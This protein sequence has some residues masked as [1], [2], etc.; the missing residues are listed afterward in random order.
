VISAAA[1]RYLVAEQASEIGAEIELALEPEGRDTLA[2]VALAAHLAARRDPL[3]TV[4]VVPSDHLIPDRDAFARSAAEAARVAASG[5]IVVLGIE[6][7]EASA[8]YGYI[9]RGPALPEGG[10]PLR[11]S[12]RSRASR[13]RG[14]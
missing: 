6:P 9:A 12:S 7:R 11:V 2:A 1:S 14:R 10:T 8:A 3:G 4:L 5:R 13:G